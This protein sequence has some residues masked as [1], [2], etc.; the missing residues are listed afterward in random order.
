MNLA[1]VWEHNGNDTLLYAQD[2]PGVYGR[3]A[4]LDAAEEK[5]LL[6]LQAYCRWLNMSIPKKPTIEIAVDA[7]SDLNIADA[8]SDAL[9]PGEETPLTSEEYAKLKAIALKS[10]AD[11]LTLYQ[12]VP[13]ENHPISPIRRTFY[14]NI[15]STAKEMYDHTKNVNAYY[16]AEIGI[17]ADNDGT[18]VECRQRAF[19]FLEATPGYLENTVFE[20]SYGERWSLRKVFRRFVW[21]D[22]IHGKAMYRR[23]VATFGVETI[24]NP[25]CF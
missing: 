9:L 21:H 20:G 3:G 24:L 15:P 7:P 11:F 22:R 2:F 25:F 13:K 8:D 12:S 14:G 18:I 23:S 19:E 1:C 6:D 10:A 17:D 16:F 5:I 4:N